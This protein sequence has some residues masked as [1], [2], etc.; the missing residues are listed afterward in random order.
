[1]APVKAAA[2]PESTT[3]AFKRKMGRREKIYPRDRVF[4]PRHHVTF[5]AVMANAAR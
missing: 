1:M 5:V 2:N 4:S 3:T